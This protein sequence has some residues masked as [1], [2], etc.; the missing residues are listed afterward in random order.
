M[1]IKA[2]FSG[3]CTV[4]GG[5]FPVGAEIEWRKGAGSRHAACAAGAPAPQ[6]AP[7]KPSRTPRQRRER[8][9]PPAGPWISNNEHPYALSDV[10]GAILTGAEVAECEAQQAI[11]ATSLPGAPSKRAGD[12]RVAVVV[13]FAARMSRSEAED[14]GYS[15][16]YSAVVRLAT[17]EEAAPL[18]AER[19]A[20]ADKRA[21]DAFRGAWDRIAEAAREDHLAPLVYVETVSRDES[22]GAVVLHEERRGVHGSISARWSRLVDGSIMHETFAY[23][24]WR[25]GRYVTGA[26]LLELART[27]TRSLDDA[28]RG[29]RYSALDRAIVWLAT[30]P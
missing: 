24:D 28:I 12:R 4:C 9:E 14:N 29:Q 1:T 13:I 10:C 20:A 16:R 15:D 6:P 19:Q 26:Q 23:D 22:R 17:A 27:S 18:L 7:A 3:T 25:C 8:A 2:R 30:H 5:D 21:W 11:T